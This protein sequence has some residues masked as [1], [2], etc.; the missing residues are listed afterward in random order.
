[1]IAS[2]S[3]TIINSFITTVFG[4]AFT[5][6]ISILAIERLPL[7]W[8]LGILIWITLNIIFSFSM[9]EWKEGLIHGAVVAIM[10]FVLVFFSILLLAIFTEAY[11]DIFDIG[12]FF[13]QEKALGF[14]FLFA[15][16]TTLLLVGISIGFSIL[17]FYLRK[18]Y[19]DSQGLETTDDIE[20]DF[21][22]KYEYP[23]H[24]EEF[25]EESSQKDDE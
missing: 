18:W 16:L 6:F 15:F 20:S 23:S 7:F 4:F 8:S 13:T 5:I 24:T 12:R 10:T 1:M 2:I 9:K 22:S 21:Y 19:K 25:N 11:F 3:K 14:S 17:G